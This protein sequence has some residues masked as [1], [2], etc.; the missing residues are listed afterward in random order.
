MAAADRGLAEAAGLLCCS[1]TSVG[2]S[3]ADGAGTSPWLAVAHA[4]RLDSQGVS[5]D[6]RDAGEL[7]AIGDRRRT[8]RW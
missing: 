6:E 4:P 8:P 2:S 3:A 5:P 7:R 1:P